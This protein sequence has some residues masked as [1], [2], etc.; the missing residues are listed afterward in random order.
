MS[1]LFQKEVPKPFIDTV[2][3]TMEQASWHTFQVLTKRSSLMARY[4]FA[5]ATATISPPHTYLV[6]RV[7]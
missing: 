1:D 6:R 5:I 3:E 7:S 4:L 2:F